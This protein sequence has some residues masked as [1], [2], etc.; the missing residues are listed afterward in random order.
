M[1]TIEFV[2]EHKLFRQMLEMEFASLEHYL[3]ESLA[4]LKS[5]ESKLAEKYLSINSQRKEEGT[6][7]YS[8]LSPYL[9]K[10]SLFISVY[11][12]FE[13]SLKSFSQLVTSQLHQYKRRVSDFEKVH[14][15]YSF[16]INEVQLDKLKTDDDWK[17]MNIFRDLRNSMVH[18]NSTIGKN[19][20][21]KT[22]EF[23][24]QDSRILFEEPRGFKIKDDALILELI[25][26]SKRLMIVLLED[27][28]RKYFS[29]ELKTN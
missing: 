16:L 24:Q 21:T 10:H 13:Y 7:T 3:V 5:S 2:K 20:S 4:A 23:I 11:S 22:Y 9:L 27:F 15:Y 8:G 14:Q 25:E 17:K 6:V 29:Q 19:I 1:V 26:V 28:E 12:F 18:Y